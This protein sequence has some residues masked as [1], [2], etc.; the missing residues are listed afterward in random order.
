[1]DNDLFGDYTFDTLGAFSLD[2]IS[3]HSITNSSSTVNKPTQLNFNANTSNNIY[4]DSGKVYPLS[5]A[6]NFI[7][8]T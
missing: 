3:G 2:Y 1:M 4:T 5:L 6:L 8:K 7:I